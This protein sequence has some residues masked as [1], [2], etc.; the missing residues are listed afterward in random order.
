MPFRKKKQYIEE[1]TALSPFLWKEP[2]PH[3]DMDT[4]QWYPTTGRY[5]KIMVCSFS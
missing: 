3:P 2:F 5:Q 1:S 4:A